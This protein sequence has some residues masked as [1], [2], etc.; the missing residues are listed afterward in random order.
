MTED[1][2]E[3]NQSDLEE[4]ISIYSA[5]QP[6]WDSED[7]SLWQ[8]QLIS[9]GFS[10]DSES[11]N[12]LSDLYLQSFE[13]ETGDISRLQLE[14][15]IEAEIQENQA[16]LDWNL[17]VQKWLGMNEWS[18]GDDAESL[19][20]ALQ[21]EIVSEKNMY[22]F[23][24]TNLIKSILE[25]IQLVAADPAAD[26][27]AI[28]LQ[29]YV[30]YLVDQ[31][32]EV[33]DD[34]LS[35]LTFLLDGFEDVSHLNITEEE[36]YISFKEDATTLS[37]FKIITGEKDGL[38]FSNILDL[39]LSEEK[40]SYTKA[41]QQFDTWESLGR[42]SPVMQ[43]EFIDQ[44]ILKGQ[45]TDI[46]YLTMLENFT[47]LEEIKDFYRDFSRGEYLSSGIK[48][49][50]DRYISLIYNEEISNMGFSESESLEEIT[51]L[52]ND[53][54][55]LSEGAGFT[56]ENRELLINLGFQDEIAEIESYGISQQWLYYQESEFYDEELS[57]EENWLEFCIKN[58]NGD[59]DQTDIESFH[60]VQTDYSNL[61]TYTSYTGESVEEYIS[62]MYPDAGY[63]ENFALTNMITGSTVDITALAYSQM[64]QELQSRLEDL[65]EIYRLESQIADLVKR[66]REENDDQGEQLL[67]E[68]Q[69]MA[70]LNTLHTDQ[71]ESSTQSR[72]LY[73]QIVQK[74]Q[75][76]NT[77][78]E[79]LSKMKT[80][81]ALSRQSMAN[82]KL[83]VVDVEFQK[84]Q[85]AVE[86]FED[87]K[88]DYDKAFSEMNDVS[89][90]YLTAQ[91]NLSEK[92]DAYQEANHLYQ[93]AKEILDYA[94]CAYTP[95]TMDILAIRNQRK[96]DYEKTVQALEIL[97]KIK[98]EG[99]TD[100]DL[101]SELSDYIAQSENALSLK[102]VLNYASEQI[103]K[104]M[105]EQSLIINNS[106]REMNKQVAQVF[107]LS[108]IGHSINYNEDY[109]NQGMTD[110]TSYANSNL[111]TTIEKY[112]KSDNAK[113]NFS[114][115][116]ILWMQKMTQSGQDMN[117]LMKTFSFA[118]YYEADEILG[119]DGRDEQYRVD[120]F[121]NEVHKDLL[122]QKGTWLKGASIGY[123]GD[124]NKY[125]I[126]GYSSDEIARVFLDYN[127]GSVRKIYV[128]PQTWLK[129]HTKATYNAIK[130]NAQLN[131]L[132][133][134]YK[135]AMQA[136]CFNTSVKTAMNLDLSY[137]AWEY[138]DDKAHDEQRDHHHWYGYDS[139]GK[140][141]KKK[142]KSLN[143]SAANYDGRLYLSA[144][145]SAV[146]AGDRAYD[147]VRAA[148]AE[149][150]KLT[151]N[152][153]ATASK[154]INI[155]NY[156]TGI[157]L[158]SDQKSLLTNSFPLVSSTFLSSNMLAINGLS[159]E[160][161]TV[162]SKIA[163][164]MQQRV[165]QLNQQ[166]NI[167]Y[168]E[169]IGQYGSESFDGDSY[170]EKARL[171]YE[172]PAYLPEDLND[173]L[174]SKALNTKSYSNSG[175]YNNLTE[176]S[177]YLIQAFQ[178]RLNVVKQSR[179][180]ELQIGLEKIYNQRD[181]WDDRTEELMA[182]GM[183][184]WL[185]S[186]EK[187]IG[188]R[189]KWRGNF[190]REYERKDQ[191]WQIR[192]DTLEKNRNLWLENSS[193]RAIESGTQAVAM[194]MGLEADQMIG[195][196][197]F[198]LIP[199]MTTSP[200]DVHDIVSDALDGTTIFSLL[201]SVKNLT[202]RTGQHNTILAAALPSLPE[203]D[204]Q[205]LGLEEQQRELKEDLQKS[206]ALAQAYKM[207]EIMKE[208]EE[209]VD[210]SIES[211]NESVDE[212][213]DST[214][215]AGGYSRQG[216]Q[217]KRSVIIDSSVFGGIEM[218]DHQIEA[219]KYY[220]APAFNHGV[221]LSI[222]TLEK[223][224]SVLIQA[225]VNKAKDNMSR[226]LTIIFGPQK[227]EIADDGTGLDKNFL[228]LLEAQENA[229]RNS[230]QYNKAYIDEEKGEQDTGKHTTTV[231]LF[232]YYVGYGPEMREDKPEKV[233][234][235]G[236]GEMGRIFKEFSIQQARLYR[237]LATVNTPTYNQKLWDDDADN[238][239][240]SDG[241]IGA[242]TA[243]SLTDIAVSISASVFLGPGAA[244]MVGM[245][246]DALFTA[247]D[248][249]NGTDAGQAW[250]SFG[251]KAAISVTSN[252]IGGEFAG[253][254]ESKFIQDSVF[255]STGLKAAEL[256]TNMTVSNGIN[257]IDWDDGL[258]FN[259]DGFAE[260]FQGQE[261]WAGVAAG[262]AGHAVTAGFQSGFFGEQFS[263]ENQ[264]NLQNAGWGSMALN[265]NSIGR[266]AGS[267]TQ[268]ATE[269]A[270]TGNT[271]VNL[272]NFDMFGIT[273]KQKQ[274]VSSGLLEFNLGKSN[275]VLEIGT[276]GIRADYSTLASV[277]EGIYVLDSEKRIQQQQASFA[278]NVNKYTDN[279][280]TADEMGRL[281]RMMRAYGDLSAKMQAAKMLS[282]ETDLKIGQ[283]TDGKA[284][285]VM[286]NGKRTVYLNNDLDMNNQNSV[287]DAIV[288]LSHEARRDGT[289][290]SES[291]QTRETRRA[292]GSHV[293]SV[294]RLIKDFGTDF[295]FGNTEMFKDYVNYKKYGNEYVDG[296]YD[297][298]ADYWKLMDNGDLVK[299]ND[300][301]LK[302][303][304]GNYKLDKDGN[305]IGAEGIE[306]G[307]L[308]ILNGGTSNKAYSEYSDA[309]I[310]AAQQ[311]MINAGFTPS[312]VENFKDRM[313]NN[314]NDGKTIKANS[315][316][317]GFGDSVAPSVFMN[318][319][320]Q[321]TDNILFG[322]NDAVTLN[323]IMGLPETSRD[324][325]ISYLSAKDSFWSGDYQIFSPETLENS[326]ATG[327]FAPDSYYP[328]G[329]HKGIDVAT[330]EGENLYSY[331]GGK[332]TRNYTSDSAGN[333]VVIN[334]GFEFEGQ[335]YSTGV[336]SQYMHMLEQSG[337]SVDDFVEPNKVV[338]QVSHTGDSQGNPGDHLHWQ[339]M[340]DNA[341]RT[342]DSSR[343]DM[344]QNRRNQFLNHI[345]GISS[346]KYSL[347][348][349]DDLNYWAGSSVE[350]GY[351][352]NNF[353]YNTNFMLNNW[354]F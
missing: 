209:S 126:G 277:A 338:G 70:A 89:A 50:T 99:N 17:S 103:Q 235:E 29:K 105:G 56:E 201:D 297:S 145:T 53:I 236:Y 336:Q 2:N 138:I 197:S 133:S 40:S 55:Q 108:K 46:E 305:R 132:Y 208:K 137:Y 162:R 335:F 308:N 214:L 347:Y 62:R 288:T 10:S 74:S 243:R 343:W 302:D 118:L 21:D 32:Y 351:S 190:K 280:Y 322:N 140:K 85:D 64:I 172:T 255:A 134:F 240:S 320:D 299:D 293:D 24:K 230:A 323:T 290:G 193:Q 130:S 3:P 102:N 274:I 124:L 318:G 195:E 164:D 114:K 109:L 127:T 312:E 346:D 330:K 188:Q 42:L 199:D 204:S 107:D 81:L 241:F 203:T 125:L 36:F 284:Q 219:Y 348:N 313:W 147:S 268:G 54:D 237:G 67:L 94:Q 257:A 27:E 303:Q 234:T 232:N 38:P 263:I 5:L 45:T 166:R 309:E 48:N 224:N 35:S 117:A 167:D 215:F 87:A 206:L 135:F 185:N 97:N 51:D 250:G 187:L 60:F 292:V 39:F 136:G 148:R 296:A 272:L 9:A 354:G 287:F 152:G 31:N 43:K 332:V 321:V 158:N 180:N 111:Q 66:E 262:T 113:E 59:T 314:G 123:K 58:G 327:R 311:L 294:D 353:Y 101:D 306:T 120:L 350:G 90:E 258:A 205:I 265:V 169:L 247:L 139:A 61:Q 184:Q 298:S 119:K 175:I 141:I 248:V 15:I 194:D 200:G 110:F 273:N 151:G 324:R 210:D 345:G 75:Y 16:L 153:D 225:R 161:D 228:A 84:Y 213:V 146:S 207:L 218:E 121:T 72:S 196:V 329:Q 88:L 278:E 28:N 271:T 325:F 198:A 260:S 159:G 131:Q 285:T 68:K 331:F 168:T 182:E 149:M 217:Y 249:Q 282:N 341:A 222:N 181:Y 157:N 289:A 160:L 286:E 100:S 6:D 4:S 270:M 252:Y 92:Y 69:L 44:T 352:Y 291:S 52:Q 11:Y 342:H 57:S 65:S 129:E 266:F 317:A 104:Q 221:D 112:F 186:T 264:K 259:T 328:D 340:G 173:L 275:N 128:T 226:Y 339:L 41:L 77:Q 239:G 179:Y 349:T 212:S 122:K 8:N 300:G 156:A 98:T 79:L 12:Q 333:S 37:W 82:Y 96:Q 233:K 242:P 261:A 76:I 251:K 326:R 18:Q 344:Y 223:L 310:Q 154:I 1:D 93:T 30:Q 143:S 78:K 254:Q 47:N 319:Y 189:E 116:I 171:L 7:L 150:R 177:N 63:L 19:T 337:Y 144:M 304:N 23:E 33:T 283:N 216:K 106:I 192:Y 22:F 238:D 26:P 163:L 229:F 281:N 91:K 34:D 253:F 334:H 13:P 295:L 316:L 315:T 202:S 49:L 20:Q 246:D 165:A 174:M 245:M 301:W 142:R 95:E 220:T 176:Y 269:Y 191:Q 231:G 86:I 267:V 178:N 256:T 73:M 183:Q 71:E 115:D 227:D 211:A 155:I 276:G 170:E 14:A 83:N 279:N 25:K 80:D 307:L 244:L